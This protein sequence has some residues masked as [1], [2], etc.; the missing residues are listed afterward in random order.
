MWQVSVIGSNV[1]E[2]RE[3]EREK[4]R[5]RERERVPILFDCRLP[6]LLKAGHKCLIFSQMT[7]ML[8]ILAV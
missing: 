2:A 4:E 8:D 6:K 7:R 3:R 5:A 1:R